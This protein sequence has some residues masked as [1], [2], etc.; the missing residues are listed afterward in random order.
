MLKKNKN[1]ILKQNVTPGANDSGDGPLVLGRDGPASC[2]QLPLLQKGEILQPLSGVGE[3]EELAHDYG[4]PLAMAKRRLLARQDAQ[5]ED[6]EEEI[7]WVPAAVCAFRPGDLNMAR[8][9]LSLGEASA[10]GRL[11]SEKGSKAPTQEVKKKRKNEGLGSD[12]AP[13]ASGKVTKK[14]KRSP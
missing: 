9:G 8:A 12:A 7:C 4:L 1:K 11:P 3:C 5:G 2:R 6:M 14:V 13:A 10:S